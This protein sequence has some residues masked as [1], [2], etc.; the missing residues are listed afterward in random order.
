[1]KKLFTI[2]ALTIGFS[3]NAQ[4]DNT[5][6]GTS[7]LAAIISGGNYNSAF[8]VSALTANTTGDANTAIG[9]EALY[10]NTTSG[11]STAV[12]NYS[13]KNSNGFYNT[14]VGRYSL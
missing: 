7:A 1:M 2:L 6:T 9:K 4:T 8:G 11:S 14:A 13:L 12:G 3:I 5:S 10:T